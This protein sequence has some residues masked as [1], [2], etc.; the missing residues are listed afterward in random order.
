MSSARTADAHRVRMIDSVLVALEGGLAL[1]A[2]IREEPEE[3]PL[4]DSRPPSS[5]GKGFYKTD[6][7]NQ[8]KKKGRG[9]KKKGR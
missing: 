4:E 7:I 5:L 9:K 2:R 1:V 3:F 8:S 6:S